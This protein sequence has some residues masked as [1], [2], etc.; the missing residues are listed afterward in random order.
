MRRNGGVS[1]GPLDPLLG[2]ALA[3]LGRALDAYRAGDTSAALLVHVE[4]F[5]AE[6][7]PVSYF[8]R[9]PEA[10]GAVD[11]SAISLAGGAVLDV[12]AC[13]GAHAEPLVRAGHAV[14]AIDVLPEAIRA[15]QARGVED[16]RLESVWTFAPAERYD[17][18]LALM[19]GASLAGTPGRL[20]PLLE[21][22][23]ALTAPAG[24]VLIDSSE[25]D[26]ADDAL[27]EAVEL[28]YQLEF[29]GR[30]GPPFPQLFAPEDVLR[31]SA[32]AAGWRMRVVARE[33]GRYLALLDR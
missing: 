3:P 16:A 4:G 15:L 2:R 11:R 33:G 24:R 21:K 23:G 12:G 9:A 30:R 32:R 27:P 18:V 7:L 14:T 25:L 20:V 17:T 8:Y 6:T 31:E 13:A 1:G 22:L 29:G 28:H 10:M 5:P 19:N 26:E